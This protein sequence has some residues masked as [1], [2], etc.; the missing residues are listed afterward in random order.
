VTALHETGDA[1]RLDEHLPDIEWSVPPPGSS[2]STFLAPSGPLATVTLGEPSAPRTVLVPGVT[3]SKEDFRFQLPLI[4]AA[5]FFVQSYDIAGQYESFR[6]GPERLDPPRANYDYELFAADLVAVLEAG[7]T[8]AHL[9]GYSFSGVVAEL[10]AVRRPDLVA[11]LTLLS[12]PPMVGQVFRG[13]MAA[14]MKWGIVRNL[15]HVPP[16]RLEFV[17][18]RFGL[19]RP[20]SRRQVLTLMRRTPDLR[21][22]LRRAPFP[23]AVAVGA[24]DLWPLR[25][26]RRFAG[27]IGASLA[28]YRSGHSPCETAPHALSRDL[29]ALFDKADEARRVG[30]R[31]RSAC[32][33]SS[34]PITASSRPLPPLRCAASCSTAASR[35]SASSSSRGSS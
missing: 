1:I 17:R 25:L 7:R 9:V 29:I 5:G 12:T 2:V 13:A 6:A 21:A 34:P 19:T 35:T 28:V 30:G 8:P 22:E 27:D 32:G 24:S 26:H 11:S 33:P 18:R 15:Q 20:A 14:L 3:G 16:G 4:A 10:V 23:R 31:T